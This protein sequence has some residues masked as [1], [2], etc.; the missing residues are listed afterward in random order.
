MSRMFVISQAEHFKQNADGD[1]IVKAE[2]CSDG[3]HTFRELYEHRYALFIALCKIY[4]NYIT[5]MNSR[6]H[7]YK[8]LKHSDGTMYHDSFILG[9]VVK[10][11]SG[12]ELQISYHLPLRLWEKINVI[13]LDY[14]PPYDGHTSND[15]IERL[16]SL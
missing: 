13:E 4:D 3:Y 14:A 8:S 10:Q 5:P 2:S 1:F 16:L 11:F 7:C 9:M 15:V 12:P 6:V